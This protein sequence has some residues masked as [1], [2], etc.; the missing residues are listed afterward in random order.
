[1]ISKIQ[2]EKNAQL[3]REVIFNYL[4][5]EAGLIVASATDDKFLN[6][7]E[8]LRENPYAGI[9]IERIN[10]KRKLIV[11]HFPFI[12][13]YVIEHNIIRIIR[14]LHTSRKIAMQYRES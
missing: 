14:I 3:D 4:F 5:R 11:P 8:L 6:L 9:Q 2:W 12:I 1:M 13:V 10:K 7:V